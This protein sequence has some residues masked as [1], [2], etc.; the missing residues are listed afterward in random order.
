MNIGYFCYIFSNS[1]NY[2]QKTFYGGFMKMAAKYFSFLLITFSLFSCRE[3]GV[4]PDVPLDTNLKLKKIIIGERNYSLYK[5]EGNKIVSL[6][7][8]KNDT[9][10]LT[11]R[12]YYNGDKIVKFE[13]IS[14]RQ[15]STDG[16]TTFEYDN[17]G[18]LVK[19]ND[20]N[21]NSNGQ[22]E[23]SYSSSFEYNASGQVTKSTII[24]PD[25]AQSAFSTL[26]YDSRGNIITITGFQNG[27]IA[28]KQVYEYNS[29][30]NPLTAISPMA[31][32]SPEAVSK[33]NI[34]KYTQETYS[35]G[36]VNQNVTHYKYEYNSK[37]YP[38]KC[39]SGGLKT[40][41]NQGINYTGYFEYEY[42]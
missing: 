39:F 9:V 11:G 8:I 7:I 37:N 42:Y 26:D 34:S 40:E 18:K 21:K 31:V 3:S 23:L 2:N 35:G 6:E 12:F 4:T 13:S 15:Y 1:G 10:T 5:F 22:F 16:Y 27:Q 17:D 38:V 19:T 33:N 30:F 32:L 14:S 29:G 28:T 20:Y 41:G 24:Y 36:V 25:G